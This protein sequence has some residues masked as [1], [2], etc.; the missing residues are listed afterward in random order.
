M[1][2]D[3]PGKGNSVMFGRYYRTSNTLYVIRPDNI[4]WDWNLAFSHEVLHYL[5]DECKMHFVND[6]QEHKVI[7]K[8]LKVHKYL[9]YYNVYSLFLLERLVKR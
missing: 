6:N 8:F 1:D 2:A 7:Y 5:F 9:H 4:R 3:P